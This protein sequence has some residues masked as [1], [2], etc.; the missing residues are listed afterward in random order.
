MNLV[1]A[2]GLAVPQ[3][4]AGQH[5]FR[6]VQE[7]YPAAAFPN[8][9]VFGDIES[10]A[11]ALAD[12]IGA[13]PFAPGPLH[14]IAHSMGGLDSRCVISRNLNGLGDRIAS[15]STISTPHAGS[16]VADLLVAPEP[17]I[18]N[19]SEHLQYET[20]TAAMRLL[21]FPAG[22]LGDL[23]TVAARKFDTLYPDRDS[24]RYFTYAG[25]G[26]YSFVLQPSSA[27]LATIGRTPDEVQNDGVVTLA[28]ARR[29]GLAE[30]P[31]P[32]DHFAEVGYDFNKLGFVSDFPHLAAIA[33]IVQRASPDN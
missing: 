10:R 17:S 18:W 22:A 12:A 11:R 4:L 7:I 25:V 15:L 3:M 28:S 30:I 5:Y 9:P 16:A 27:F 8:V 1:F 29:N 6:G 24:V 14:I 33:R 19:F 20:I 21:G 13:H 31:W 23:T 2:S 26:L 32:A